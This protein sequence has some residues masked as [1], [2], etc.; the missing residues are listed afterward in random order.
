MN[1]LLLDRVIGD[2]IGGGA[3]GVRSFAERELF[4]PLDMKSVT[5]EFDGAGTFLGASHFYATPR[6]YARFGQL[7]MND[8]VTP[9]GQRILP[10]GWVAYSRKSTLGSSYGAGFWTNDGP[11]QYAADRVAQGF[12]KDGFFA[13]GN[14]GQRI[15]IVPSQHFVMVRFG[16]SKGPDFGIGEDLRLIKTALEETSTGGS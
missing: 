2:T 10:Q 3:Q 5:M 4:R 8:G 15:Y 1:T 9:E 7:Y 12:P 16:Y 6:D 13:S 14:E 11:S